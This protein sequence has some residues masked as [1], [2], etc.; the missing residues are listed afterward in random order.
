MVQRLHNDVSERA[1]RDDVLDHLRVHLDLVV[2]LNELD[3]GVDD[4]V[5]Q[6]LEQVRAVWVLSF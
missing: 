4:V 1:M 3:V 6:D 2:V 5:E